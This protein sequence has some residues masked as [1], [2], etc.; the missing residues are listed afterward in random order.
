METKPAQVLLTDADREME[1][2]VKKR[3]LSIGVHR[4]LGPTFIY[5]L[6]LHALFTASDTAFRKIV[7]LFLKHSQGEQP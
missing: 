7:N 4:K 2:E 1:A 6:G 5:R 3:L